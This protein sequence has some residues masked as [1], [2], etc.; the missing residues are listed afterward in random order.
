MKKQYLPLLSDVLK[1]ADPKHSDRLPVEIAVRVKNT[2]SAELLL[3]NTLSREVR[4]GTALDSGKERLI[5]LKGR[6][7]K[8]MELPCPTDL[9]PDRFT[10]LLFPLEFTWGSLRRKLTFSISVL[11]VRYV[12]EGFPGIRFRRFRWNM[13]FRSPIRRA[14]CR[15]GT[16]KRIFP[17]P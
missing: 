3:H 11:P 15:N 5:V 4:L 1:H 13:S 16:G 17:E 7:R 14:N 2:K 12:R 8:S 10:S 6:E 9:S